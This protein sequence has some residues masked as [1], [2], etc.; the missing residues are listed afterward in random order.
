MEVSY[1]VMAAFRF[2]VSDLSVVCHFCRGY[3]K[4]KGGYSDLFI[5]EGPNETKH[6]IT[7]KF[8]RLNG[9]PQN[10]KTNIFTPG[11]QI[12]AFTE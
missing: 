4:E 6:P 10:S 9:I 7:P 1:S 5:F 12:H 2:G 8:A 11:V 3:R